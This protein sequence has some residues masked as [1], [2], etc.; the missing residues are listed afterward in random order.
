MIFFDDPALNVAAANHQ[1][2]QYFCNAAVSVPVVPPVIWGRGGGR[3]PGP[4]NPG[5]KRRI[6]QALQEV[7][8]DI[9]KM[10]SPTDLGV[11][12]FNMGSKDF[13]TGDFDNGLGVDRKFKCQF[14]RRQKADN[15]LFVNCRCP[16]PCPGPPLPAA[17][18]ATDQLSPR[19]R[20][21]TKISLTA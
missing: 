5:G 8:W 1:N 7:G 21:V 18:T 3:N 11:P 20:I 15:N 16:P 12:A 2:I 4:V 9:G 19:I 17:R 13:S 6:H 10:V 14:A